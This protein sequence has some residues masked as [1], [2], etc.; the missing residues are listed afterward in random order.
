MATW[1]KAS[2]WSKS[3][4][5]WYTKFMKGLNWAFNPNHEWFDYD[6]WNENSTMNKIEGFLKNATQTVGTALSSMNPGDQLQS[7]INSQTGA[8]LTGS[9]VE[10]NEMQM[11]NQEDIYQRQVVG[12]QKAGLNPALMYQSGASSAP[13]VQGSQGIGSMSEIM[14]AMLLDKQSKLLEAQTRNTDA[15][16]NKKESETAYQ[17]LINK[18]YPGVKSIELDKTLSEIGLNEQQIEKMKSE[19]DLNKLDADLKK[20]E[21]VIKQAEA[22]ES[23][24]YYKAVREYQEAATDK[25]KQEKAKLVVETAM[26][27]L[28]RNYMDKYEAKMSSSG[29]LALIAYLNSVV[30]GLSMDSEGINEWFGKW[31]YK[32]GSEPYFNHWLNEIFGI[33]YWKNGGSR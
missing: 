14:Q 4:D 15:D 5:R 11:Q 20:I 12:M 8:H 9:Q 22:N 27:E 25:A 28:E 17:E 21:K 32:E 29:V 1:Y 26:D 18:Y 19:V 30:S 31:I 33:H 7:F 6:S 10:A 3:N 13:Q 2:G 16:T 24:A 23:S